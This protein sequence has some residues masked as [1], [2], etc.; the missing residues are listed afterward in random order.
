M[1]D[2]GTLAEKSLHAAL[3]IWYS[4]PN[5]KFEVKVENFVIDIVRDKLLIE[6]Q[7]GNFG[8][9]KAKLKRLL[10]THQIHIIYPIPQ[11]KW[12]VRQTKEGRLIKRRK[13]PK[14]GKVIDI[15]KE[16]VRIAELIPNA[17]LSLEVLLTHQEEL[18]RDDG[19]GSWRRK[20]WSIYDHYL[21]SVV[22]QLTFK[23]PSDFCA[24][25]PQTLAEPF[26]NRQLATALT[27]NLNMAQKMSY[28]L[29]KM[30]KFAV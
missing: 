26:T 13:S 24:L 18:W 7:T 4:Q 23:S 29:R 25:L 5:D 15:F 28:S 10:P 12:I 16:L 6:I 1:S 8:A 19:K 21:L 3:K 20:R 9:M 2:I 27:C 17:N 14:R 30:G 11:Q 22:E